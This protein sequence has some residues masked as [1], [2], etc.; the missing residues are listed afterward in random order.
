LPRTRETSHMTDPPQRPSFW[1]DSVGGPPAAAP[2]PWRDGVRV[3]ICGVGYTGLWTAWDL[4]RLE[5]A[6][7][8]A[9]YE[10]EHVGCG[11][12]GRNGGWCVGLAW[13]LD[14][15]LARDETRSRGMA[16]ARE[17]FATVDEV[18]RVCQAENID[19]H[20]A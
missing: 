13:G 14:G 6:L 3:A 18:G 10:A 15:L 7:D 17:L 1:F 11:A 5:P 2:P 16:L 20:Y 4:K 9:V 19:A 8:I 12:S